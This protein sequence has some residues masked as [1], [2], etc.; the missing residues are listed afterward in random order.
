MS[1]LIGKHHNGDL[2]DV[3]IKF[4]VAF[5]SLAHFLAARDHNRELAG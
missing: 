1:T 5:A 4:H 3:H 2:P